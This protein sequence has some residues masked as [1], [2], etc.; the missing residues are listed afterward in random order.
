MKEA[1]K[2]YERELEIRELVKQ[3][4]YTSKRQNRLS[5][6]IKKEKSWLDY[7]KRRGGLVKPKE[8]KEGV[9]KIV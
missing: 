1:N 7:I 2:K 8:E 4:K 9:D 6:K 3:G 5:K